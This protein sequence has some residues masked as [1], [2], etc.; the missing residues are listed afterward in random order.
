MRHPSVEGLAT[1]CPSQRHRSRETA[2]EPSTETARQ[3]QLRALLLV[4]LRE[5][6]SKK[7]RAKRVFFPSGN[8]TVEQRL[9]GSQRQSEQAAEGRVIVV[10]VPLGSFRCRPVSVVRSL[11]VSSG[12]AFPEFPEEPNSAT[13]AS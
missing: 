10:V 7:T 2:I 5:P 6:I 8:V 1:K 4:S 9:V 3:R 13:R 12:C 11:S